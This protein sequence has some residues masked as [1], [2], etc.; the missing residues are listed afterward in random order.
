MNNTMQLPKKATD[1][2]QWQVGCL[3]SKIDPIAR[4]CKATLA[5]KHPSPH[6]VGAYLHKK[7]IHLDKQE[8]SFLLTKIKSL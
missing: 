4:S 8:F 7:G 5:K 1:F 2:R 6:D 3:E